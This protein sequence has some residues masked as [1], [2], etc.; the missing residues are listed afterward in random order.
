[1]K[2]EKAPLKEDDDN[3]GYCRLVFGVIC[4]GFYL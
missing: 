1:M 3:G 4:I 2:Y